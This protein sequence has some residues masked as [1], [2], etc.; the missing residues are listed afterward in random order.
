[1][2]LAGSVIEMFLIEEVS[3]LKQYFLLLILS[4]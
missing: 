3:F 2:S 4:V 1:M